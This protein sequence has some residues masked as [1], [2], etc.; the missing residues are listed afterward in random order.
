MFYTDFTFELFMGSISNIKEASKD[1]TSTTVFID[2]GYLTAVAIMKVKEL[3]FTKLSKELSTGTWNK[4]IV[5]DALPKFEDVS[6]YSKTRHFHN[7]LRKLPK[8]EVKLGRLQY[9]KGNPIGQKGVD[10]KIGIDLVQMSMNHDFTHAVLI[11]GDSD[12]LYAVQ[13][14]QE[15]GIHVTLAHLQ[16]T[17]I[18]FK[19]F[20]SF[21]G[22]FLLHDSILDRWKI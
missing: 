20:Q 3:N 18:N 5:Y 1:M 2:V 15:A 22:H 8:F 11:T 13:K 17:Q 12:F 16:G 9:L 6:R 7:A 21:D 14:S 4:T 19:F 10:M